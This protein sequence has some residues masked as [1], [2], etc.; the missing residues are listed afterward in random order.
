MYKFCAILNET[1]LIFVSSCRNSKNRKMKII[2]PLMSMTVLF[3][4]EEV[5]P[6]WPFPECA[7]FVINC[8][9]L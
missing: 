2:L 8:V 3:P 5:L 4:F 9:G 7:P 6:F 1:G